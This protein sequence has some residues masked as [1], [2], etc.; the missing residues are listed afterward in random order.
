MSPEDPRHG[1]DA[2]YWT[3]RRDHESACR[4]CR[5]GHYRATTMVEAHAAELT[6][7]RW[8]TKNGIKVWE[9]DDDAPPSPINR[10]I[11]VTL[12]PEAMRRGYSQYRM[13]IRTEFA[14]TAQREYQR[15]HKRARRGAA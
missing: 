11:P 10:R 5:I 2:G 3:H 1:T 7:G 6:G 8:V 12:T 9:Y 13:G 15:L 4:P 14:I